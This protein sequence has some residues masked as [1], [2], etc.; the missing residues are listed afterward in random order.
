MKIFYQLTLT[1]A[2]AFALIVGISHLAVAQKVN[3]D[4]GP[5]PEKDWLT[6]PKVAALNEDHSG[7]KTWIKKWYGP[8]GNYENNGGFAG[9]APKDLIEEA[10]NGKLDQVK[11]STAAGLKLDTDCGHQL[12]KGERGVP[13]MDCL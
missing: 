1:T 3:I 9:S 6:N 12:E 7:E 10:T 13:G 5:I 8:D 4:D 11:L 2:I